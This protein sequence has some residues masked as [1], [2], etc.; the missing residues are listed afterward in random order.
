[1]LLQTDDSFFKGVTNF[2]LLKIVLNNDHRPNK[3]CRLSIHSRL[4]DAI[5]SFL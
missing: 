1:M 5:A 2:S 3:D 4:T